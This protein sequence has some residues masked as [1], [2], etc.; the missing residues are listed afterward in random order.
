[1]RRKGRNGCRFTPT[2]IWFVSSSSSSSRIVGSKKID[3]RHRYLGQLF[4]APS[5]KLAHG[6][7]LVAKFYNY[8]TLENN[9]IHQSPPSTLP[10]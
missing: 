9:L 8:W 1:M 2:A 6:K 4:P 3:T 10:F 5:H 7:R